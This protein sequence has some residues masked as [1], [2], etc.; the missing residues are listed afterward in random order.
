MIT[1]QKKKKKNVFSDLWFY[2]FLEI[3]GSVNMETDGQ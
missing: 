3:L 2:V 1:L